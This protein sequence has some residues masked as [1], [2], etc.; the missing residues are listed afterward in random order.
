MG[1]VETLPDTP[2]GELLEGDHSDEVHLACAC[3]P[4]LAHCGVFNAAIEDVDFVPADSPVC[5]GCLTAWE[6]RG[7]GRCGCNPAQICK[8]CIASAQGR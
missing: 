8:A 4:P 6:T 3:R 2:L 5:R 7:C 1:E